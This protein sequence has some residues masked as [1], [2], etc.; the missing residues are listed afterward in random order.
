MQQRTRLQEEQMKVNKWTVGLAAAGLVTLPWITQAEEKA[1]SPVM[2]AVSSTT[3][4]GYVDTSAHWNL[5]SGNANP[6]PYAFNSANKA[7][8]FNLDSVLVSIS[9]PLS[10][11]TWGAG[12]RADIWFG[13]DAN[14]FG[15]SSTGFN[16]NDVNIRQAYALLRAPVGNGLDFKLGVYDAIVGYESFDNYLNAN[17]T[18][19]YAMLLEPASHT[20]VLATYHLVDWLDLSA[21][22]ANTEGPQI[23]RKAWQENRFGVSRAES[24]KTYMGSIGLVAPDSWGFLAGSKLNAGIVSGF[25]PNSPVEESSQN[26]Y[27]GAQ[28]NTPLAGLTVG[29][30]Y[31]FVHHYPNGNIDNDSARAYGVYASFKPQDSKWGFHARGE[32]AEAFFDTPDNPTASSLTRADVF[33]LTGTVSYDLWKNVL[34][35]VE[36]RWDHAADGSNG[37]KLFGGEVT[38]DPERKNA[39]LLAANVIYKF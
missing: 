25:N 6:A 22:I 26:Y 7:D 29:A 24:S 14:V 13:P 4:S 10:E 23:N 19:S 18:R 20:G 32:Y 11:E 9:K 5:G 28:L 2:T 31:D 17:Y 37:G 1:L 38:G 35:R 30:A 3:I 12:Y 33:A 16:V 34:T 8:G 15:T 36:F 39:Y 27:A 21:G